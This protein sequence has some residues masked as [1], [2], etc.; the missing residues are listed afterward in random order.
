MAYNCS[1]YWSIFWN[2]LLRPYCPI[3]FIQ[4]PS[5]VLPGSILFCDDKKLPNSVALFSWTRVYILRECNG[6]IANIVE[7]IQFS[8]I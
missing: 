8:R 1:K 2:V 6:V 4:G 7:P 3:G 5:N